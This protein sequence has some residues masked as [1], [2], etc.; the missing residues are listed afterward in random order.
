M[1]KTDELKHFLD[2]KVKLY[3]QTT[4]IEQD[5]ICIPHGFSLKQDMEIAGFFAATLAWGLRKTIISKCKYLLSLMDNS[6]YDFV[7]NHSDRDLKSLIGFKH[8]TFNDTDL[9]YFIRFFKRH[10]LQNDSLEKAFLRSES[11]NLQQ[12]I[13][14]FQHYFFEDEFAPSRTRKHVA[15]PDRHSA[16]KRIN[17]FLRWMVRKDKSGVDFGIWNTIQPKELICPLDVHV[18]RTARKLKLLSRKQDD[19][20]SAKLLT[21][22]LLQ[23]DPKDPVK[24]DFALFGLGVIEKF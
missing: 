4:F 1:S 3:N 16:C 5:P 23:F 22:R 14:S 2:E 8:R 17:M 13:S 10:Y 18:G 11:K 6:P 15:T 19:W 9:L 24:Y 12:R 21:D 20:K 7:L